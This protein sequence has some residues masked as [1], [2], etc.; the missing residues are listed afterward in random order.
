MFGTPV[1]G[2]FVITFPALKV[3]ALSNPGV[4]TGI[5]NASKP[6]PS[7]DRVTPF[8]IIS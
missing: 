3:G 2:S 5:G 8:S 4:D 1:S 6:L 7:W